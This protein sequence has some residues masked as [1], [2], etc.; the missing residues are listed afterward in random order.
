[1]GLSTEAFGVLLAALA[2]GSLVGAASAAAL[3]RRLGRANT[4]MVMI[5]TMAAGLV[6][7]AMTTRPAAVAA[8]FVVTGFSLVVYSVIVSLRQ[9]IVPDRLLGRVNAGY[10]LVAWGTIP[11]GSARGAHRQGCQPARGLRR[12]RS[13][14]SCWWSRGGS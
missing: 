2:V 4:L 8:W 10:R 12:R 11:I 1:M 7:P 9:G 14:R 6:G 5:V 3:Q 13:P